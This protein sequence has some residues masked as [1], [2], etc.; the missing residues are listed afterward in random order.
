MI[1][2]LVCLI[3]LLTLTLSQSCLS[4]DGKPV[5]WWVVIKVPPKTGHYGYGYYDSTMKTATF[6]YHS[7]RIDQG[8]TPL[9]YTFTEINSL[10]MEHI[11]WND[12]KP[13]GEVSSSVAHSK[14]II[15]YQQAGA[16][17]KGLLLTHSI[18]KYP[19]FSSGNINPTIADSQNY[20]GQN[21]ACYSMTIK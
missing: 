6:I 16:G 11:A 4:Q 3:F 2:Q 1:K 20:Y 12:E 13:T 14:G 5:A 17:S 19:A 21:L 15:A 9:T 8:N 18:P 7:N 10:K